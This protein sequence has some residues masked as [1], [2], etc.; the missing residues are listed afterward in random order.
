MVDAPDCVYVERRGKLE[1]TAVQFESPEGLRAA[2]D[3]ILALDGVALSPEK[4]IGEM[5]FPDGSRFLAAVPPPAV[6][7]PYLVL[8]R[9]SPVQITWDKLIEYQAVTPE[10][11]DLLES[12]IR[13]PVSILVAG[14]AGSGKTT[15]L[16]RLIDLVPADQRVVIVENVLELQSARHP[17]I[18]HLEA[19]GPARV[20]FS[21]LLTTASCMR[22][23]WLI[24]GELLGSEAMHAIQIMGRGHTG[25][26]TLHANG[27]EDALARLEAMCL[28][29]NLGLGLGDIRLLI[30][31]AFRLITYQE[32]LPNGQR[33]ILHIAELRG[34]EHDRFVLQPLMRYDPATERLAATG[35]KPCWMS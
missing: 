28:M 15:M 33:R 32:K 23:D 16:N 14:G 35:A 1:D 13:A 12:A 26:A 7:G 5:R 22:P 19:G 31:S 29:A 30:A 25:M 27:V 4:T 11:R 34:V 21:D 9:P 10:A 20:A 2:I 24:C 8:R 6:G 3:A 18:V 17:H